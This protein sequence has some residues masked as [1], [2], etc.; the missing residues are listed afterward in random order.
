MY[1]MMC[2]C[3]WVFGWVCV[4]SVLN[5]IVPFAK[6]SIVVTLWIVGFSPDLL[7][8]IM[9]PSFISDAGTP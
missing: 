7:K 2:Y 8:T 9:S 4:S 5:L 6:V 3:P 1:V